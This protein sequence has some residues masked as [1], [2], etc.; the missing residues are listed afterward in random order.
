MPHVGG[1]QGVTSRRRARDIR[2]AHTRAVAVLP[3]VGIRARAVRPQPAGRPQRVTL[4][5]RTTKRRSGQDLRWRC[6]RRANGRPRRAADIS[7][8]RTATRPHAPPRPRQTSHLALARPL[9]QARRAPSV[10]KMDH[11]TAAKHHDPICSARRH[12]ERPPHLHRIPS[13]RVRTR[14]R[15]Q[16]KQRTRTRPAVRVDASHEGLRPAPRGD[17]HADRV[18]SRRDRVFETERPGGAA[19]AYS[20]APFDRPIA[21]QKRVARRLDFPRNGAPGR[22]GRPSRTDHRARPSGCCRQ[23]RAQRTSHPNLSQTVLP[24][25]TMASTSYGPTRHLLELGSAID[26]LCGSSAGMRR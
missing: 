25:P 23:Q 15:T 22:T 8:D 12:A 16:T 21:E 9:A 5:D 11:S 6:R 20:T 13:M 18:N 14:K 4:L 7:R 3:R 26:A 2:T 10:A 1:S 19:T 24:V 17:K